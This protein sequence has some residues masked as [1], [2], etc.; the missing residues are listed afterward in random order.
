[1]KKKVIQTSS[2]YESGYSSIYG[3]IH[4]HGWTCIFKT[5]RVCSDR[6][7][8]VIFRKFHPGESPIMTRTS[9]KCCRGGKLKLIV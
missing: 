1:M 8:E 7:L 9:S 6:Q 5:K 3:Q 2:F 4:A